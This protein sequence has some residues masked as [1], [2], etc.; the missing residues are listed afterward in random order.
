MSDN[1]GHQSFL[2]V[3]GCES[4]EFNKGAENLYSVKL[5]AILLFYFNN[6]EGDDDENDRD[7]DKI[8]I[9]LNQGVILVITKW[10]S[11]VWM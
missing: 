2:E 11:I 4:G 3:E 5:L 7:D 10:T 8:V 6:D 9:D 1:S